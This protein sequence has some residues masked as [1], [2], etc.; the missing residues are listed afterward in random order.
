LRCKR[1]FPLF[2][3]GHTKALLSQ[4]AAYDNYVIDFLKT[5]QRQDLIWLHRIKLAD[6]SGV[7][8]A[9]AEEAAATKNA[10]LKRVRPTHAER[11]HDPPFNLTT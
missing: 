6:Y 1:Q 10:H 11:T 4:N 2:K 5:K 8:K 9:L 7:A 3:K